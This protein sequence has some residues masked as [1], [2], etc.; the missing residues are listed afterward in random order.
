MGYNSEPIKSMPHPQ[1]LCFRCCIVNPLKLDS[2]HC[3]EVFQQKC[4]CTSHLQ[5]TLPFFILTTVVYDLYQL[6]SLSLVSFPSFLPHQ[7][8]FLHLISYLLT[9]TFTKV[10]L[11]WLELVPFKS[12]L[13]SCNQH[14]TFFKR[15]GQ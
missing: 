7:H 10:H 14:H 2:S 8:I 12:D 9:A 11:I 15:E 13:S 5:P 1:L 6:W 3:Q 4:M